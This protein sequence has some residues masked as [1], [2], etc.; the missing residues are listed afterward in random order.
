[1]APGKAVAQRRVAVLGP[2]G[3]HV[4]VPVVRG[5]PQ[6]AALRGGCAQHCEGELHPAPGAKRLMREVAVI[7][8]GDGEH[9]KCIQRQRRDQ[10]DRAHADPGQREAAGVDRDERHL[11]QPVDAARLAGADTAGTAVEPGEAERAQAGGTGHRAHPRTRHGKK[12]G[13]RCTYSA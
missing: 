11:A 7:E 9:A 3:V 4:V 1:M 10:R 13:V 8:A 6:R 12:A 2:V 5:P